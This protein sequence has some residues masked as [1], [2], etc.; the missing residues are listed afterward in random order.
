VESGG[1]DADGLALAFGVG[2]EAGAVEGAVDALAEG[3]GAAGGSSERA[4]PAAAT[5]Q[6][7]AALAMNDFMGVS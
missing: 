2:A 1:V 7:K 5:R 6:I 3:A 4:G